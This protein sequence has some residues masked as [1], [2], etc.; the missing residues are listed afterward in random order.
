MALFGQSSG[1]VPPFDP[2]HSERQG[3]AVS[4][5]AQPGPFTCRRATNCSGA[6][7][8]CSAGSTPGKL[9]LRI[10]R[11]YPLAE[12]AAGAP[13]SGRPPH[14]RQTAAHRSVNRMTSSGQADPGYGAAGHRDR[15]RH[16]G[17]RPGQHHGLAVRVRAA[18]GRPRGRHR[19]S[20]MCGMPSTAIPKLALHEAL[21]SDRLAEQLKTEVDLL[22]RDLR[23]RRSR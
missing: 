4:D 10:D 20:A 15:S 14:H 5:A 19:W 9:K 6:P 13:R 8:T 17:G 1:P 12:A 11:T 22:Q 2:E 3:L 23:S 18:A 21:A 7:A 16:L